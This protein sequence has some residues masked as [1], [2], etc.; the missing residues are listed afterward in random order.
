MFLQYAKDTVIY[1]DSIRREAIRKNVY[2]IEYA[3]K[4]PYH[5]LWR[6]MA[7]D[8]DIVLAAVN[9]DWHALK[10]ASPK[11]RNDRDVV[12]AAVSQDWRALFYASPE[13]RNDGD[14]RIAAKGFYLDD[15]GDDLEDDLGDD[16][17]D[18]GD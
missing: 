8:K 7:N 6:E 12:L 2:A 13:L 4:Y 3:A 15:I 10:Y 11:L 5:D 9:Q 16:P 18:I 17:G 1:D 14:I